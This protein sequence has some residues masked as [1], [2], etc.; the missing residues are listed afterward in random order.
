MRNLEE[1]FMVDLKVK[2]NDFLSTAL[3]QGK[4]RV[5]LPCYG[6]NLQLRVFDWGTENGFSVDEVNDTDTIEAIEK[7]IEAYLQ[8]RQDVKS[9]VLN[10]DDAMECYWEIS[11]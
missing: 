2:I 4:T 5:L 10:T 1:E 7:D 9:L 6:W 11:L 8:S 3:K